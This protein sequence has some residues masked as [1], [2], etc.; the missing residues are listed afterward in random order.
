MKGH[1]QHRVQVVEKFYD[2]GPPY[3]RVRMAANALDAKDAASCLEKLQAVKTQEAAAQVVLEEAIRALAQSNERLDEIEQLKW[4][5]SAGI[6]TRS[7]QQT[8]SRR[9]KQNAIK[10]EVVCGWKKSAK[11]KNKRRQRGETRRMKGSRFKRQS[12]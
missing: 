7:A 12:D 10:K 9:S 6:I 11:Y 5:K 1:L 3:Y 8:P 2:S 4:P